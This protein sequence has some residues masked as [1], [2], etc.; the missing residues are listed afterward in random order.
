M[1]LSIEA[2]RAL[3]GDCLLVHY[4]PPDAP[5]TVLIDGGPGVVY[6][7]TLKPR[8]L[9]IRA[10]MVAAGTIGATD[11]LPLALAMVSHCDDDHIGGLVALTDDLDGGLGLTAVCWVKPKTLWHNTFEDLTG[12]PVDAI[13]DVGLDDTTS[14]RTAAVIA[15]VPQARVLI[16]QAEVCGWEINRGFGGELVQAPENGGKLV[17]LGDETTVTILAPRSDEVEGLRKEWKKQMDRVKGGE[18]TA[19]HVAAYVDRSPFNLSSIVCL[20]RQGQ[21]SMLLTGDARGDLILKGL[22]AAGATVDGLVHVDVLKV[23][24]HGSIRDVD[25]DFFDRIT[26]DHYV[27][28]ASGRYGNPESQTLELIAASRHTD[29]FT[30]HLTYDKCESDLAERVA[31]FIE[32]RDAAG[33]TFAITPRADNALSLRIDLGDPF[34]F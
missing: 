8:L 12:T 31:A 27:I 21:R 18:T 28:S 11:P 6:G 5:R 10:R 9:E 1:I 26:A 2:L 16:S 3:H 13:A 22:D 4:G 14:G 24:H 7:A 23:P 33:R 19:A 20:I 30:I 17:D 32:A 34:P 25:T 29:N 15:S